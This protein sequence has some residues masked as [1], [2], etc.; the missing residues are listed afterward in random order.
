MRVDHET[1]GGF[2]LTKDMTDEQKKQFVLDLRHYLRCSKKLEGYAKKAEEID[3]AMKR[4][5]DNRPAI[6]VGEAPGK[7]EKADE[8][9]FIDK[10]TTFVFRKLYADAS[11]KHPEAVKVLNEKVDGLLEEWRK[12]HPHTVDW[13][14]MKVDPPMVLCGCGHHEFPF[15]ADPYQAHREFLEESGLVE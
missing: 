4:S 12:N 3:E 14:M 13:Y 9:K 7:D 8:Q 11:I 10:E 1:S 15:D 5:P 2:E 6:V